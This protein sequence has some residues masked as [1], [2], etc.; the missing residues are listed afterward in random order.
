MLYNKSMKKIALFGFL[1]ALSI[2]P[3]F[4]AAY[5]FTSYLARGSS[6][7]AVR[8]L[9]TLLKAYPD[10]YPEGLVTGY[11]GGL[12]ELAV[13]KF[14][15]KYG[16]EQLGVVGPRTRAELNRQGGVSVSS[17]SGIVATPPVASAGNYTCP[18]ELISQLNG[19]TLGVWS[20]VKRTVTALE[21]NWIHANCAKT[22]GT[23]AY[24][25]AQTAT[26]S[27]PEELRTRPQLSTLVVNGGVTR[28][29]GGLEQNWIQQNCAAVT[30]G[31][32]GHGWTYNVPV[33]SKLPACVGKEL[34][35]VSPMA[36]N[37]VKNLGPLGHITTPRHAF[38]MEHMEYGI[39]QDAQDKTIKTTL[40]A[41]GAVHIIGIRETIYKKDGMPDPN[42]PYFSIAFTPCKDVLFYWEGM[43]TISDALR[44]AINRATSTLIVEG[45][46]N[47]PNGS[48]MMQYRVDYV[49]KAGEILGS[50]GGPGTAGGA[51]EWGGR[52]FRIPKLGFLGTPVPDARVSYT[53]CPIDYYPEP[54]KSTLYEKFARKVSP[55]CGLV[56]QDLAGTIQGNW[57]GV[58]YPGDIGDAMLGIVHHNNSPDIGIIAA[59]GFIHSHG[60]VFFNPRHSGTL[61]REPSEVKADGQIYCYQNGDEFA[62]GIV[63]LN[64]SPRIPG[65]ILVQLQSDLTLKVEQQNKTCAEPVSFVSPKTYKR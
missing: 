35:S 61:N 1:A 37:E 15:A 6:G 18:G 26:F 46:P 43:H 2:A 34:L 57:L 22:P 65:R 13:K 55:R 24:V 9:Q 39:P 44:Q 50:V 60:T 30:Q 25:K 8:E 19:P 27:C 48:A 31:V 7:A 42:H 54:L 4:A 20:G 64:I 53:V 56:M 36:V 10:L 58:G 49:T 5:T 51:L 59:S 14:Q 21:Q 40:Y 45:N 28:E 52:D 29:A 23:E 38:P 47:D 62:P 41:P 12:T 33:T 3:S 17:G 16:I 11:F 63:N 32:A